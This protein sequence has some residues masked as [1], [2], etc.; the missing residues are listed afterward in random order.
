M[1]TV[2]VD[3]YR[4][5]ISCAN[6]LQP[7]GVFQA[8]L[9]VPDILT[10]KGL[11]NPSLTSVGAAEARKAGRALVEAGVQYDLV[12]SSPLARAVQTAYLMLVEPRGH[13]SAPIHILPHL[14]EHNPLGSPDNSVDHTLR[15]PEFLAQIDKHETLSGDLVT[16]VLDTDSL[17][18]YAGAGDRGGGDLQKFL[19]ETLP[20]FLDRSAPGQRDEVRV[21]VATHS[22]LMKS[23]LGLTKLPL[24]NSCVRVICEYERR[25]ALVD[26]AVS[27]VPPGAAFAG[28]KIASLAAR[29]DR[30]SLFC[31]DTACS[32]RRSPALQKSLDEQCR[33]ARPAGAAGVTASCRA[34]ADCA[35]RYDTKRIPSSCDR[36][37]VSAGALGWA[38]EKYAVVRLDAVKDAGTGIFQSDHDPVF[39]VARH[40]E[41][42]VLVVTFN[43]AGRNDVNWTAFMAT[44]CRSAEAGLTSFAAV[45]IALQE[46]TAAD[47]CAASLGDLLGWDYTVHEATSETLPFTDFRV[48]CIAALRNTVFGGSRVKLGSRSLNAVATK[49]WSRI[50]VEPFNSMPSLAFV[51]A[52]LPMVKSDKATLG[53]KRRYAA[54]R[55]ISRG[56]P[57]GYWSVVAGDLN[58]RCHDANASM[59]CDELRSP[60]GRALLEDL[61]LEEP[62]ALLARTCKLRTVSYRSVSDRS[63]SDRIV[64]EYDLEVSDDPIY[65]LPPFPKRLAALP[66]LPALPN[67][68]FAHPLH[69]KLPQI[70]VGGGAAALSVLTVLAAVFGSLVA[71][72][73]GAGV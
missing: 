65:E 47:P 49:S 32:T 24:N 11:E 12:C 48:R 17:K 16:A 10:N 71:V 5:G 46:T 42:T 69:R 1:V 7:Q 51:S 18:L 63:V 40:A 72:T 66:A 60:E 34:D 67:R 56:L 2:T 73:A 25:L 55:E 68:E 57:G 29:A 61:S 14:R 43:C 20:L 31:G 28:V 19:R 23:G 21:A 3:F 45:V 70:S 64:A 30:F 15:D 41:H 37:L 53:M 44:V 39:A 26:T 8:P 58:F 33:K 6:I 36:I 27:G 35:E 62:G 50:T 52:H 54:L 59:E 9:K 38:V 22:G 13:G 4:H